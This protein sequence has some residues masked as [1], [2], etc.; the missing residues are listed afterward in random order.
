MGAGPL[1]LLR[2]LRTYLVFRHPGSP[3]TVVYRPCQDYC[4]PNIYVVASTGEGLFPHRHRTGLAMHLSVASASMSRRP[5]TETAKGR[6]FRHFWRQCSR[7][8][9]LF[10]FFAVRRHF[11][12]NLFQL[13]MSSVF[14]TRM[15]WILSIPLY[16]SSRISRSTFFSEFSTATGGLLISIPAVL[17]FPSCTAQ[18][19]WVRWLSCTCEEIKDFPEKLATSSRKSL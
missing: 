3:D 9:L 15:S 6:S 19:V 17:N 14:M 13:E 4:H 1:I 12:G 8:L 7:Y 16:Q 11:S 10:P 2:L 5:S 18:P